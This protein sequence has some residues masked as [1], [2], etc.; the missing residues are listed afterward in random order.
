MLSKIP[1]QKEKKHFLGS[2]GVGVHLLKFDCLSI[3]V[4]VCLFIYLIVYI[5][6]CLTGMPQE[7]MPVLEVDGKKIPQSRA[8]DRF[9]AREFG[10]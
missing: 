2:R 3:H 7:A 5:F 1:V 10:N 9:L 6:D 4:F 8:I